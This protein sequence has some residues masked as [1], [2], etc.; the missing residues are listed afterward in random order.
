MSNQADAA[1]E[2]GLFDVLQDL[3][4]AG[5]LAG[6]DY[7]PTGPVAD[8]PAAQRR[9]RI[10]ATVRQ[11]RFDL[12]LALALSSQMHDVPE[13]LDLIAGRPLLY[14]EGDPWGRGKPIPDSMSAWLAVSDWVFSVGGEPQSSLLRRHGARVV[15]PTVHTY[16]HLLFAHEERAFDGERPPH[17]CVFI[18]SN[19]A[20]VPGL[21]GLPGSWDRRSLVMRLR[22]CLGPGFAVAG[23]GWPRRI[24]ASRVPF[25]QQGT[26]I[27]SGHILA[28][29][30]H[31]PR[32]SGYA[33]DRLAITMISG[34]AQVT[35]KHPDMSWAPPESSGVF[36][37]DT[38]RDV[39]Q[40]ILGLLEDPQGALDLGEAA[41]LW[42]QG[43][44]SLRHA[45][46]YMLSHALESLSPP[47][48]EP[49]SQ[50]TKTPW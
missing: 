35:T 39:E 9:A 23:A 29:W 11:A 49:W 33:S 12:V 32:T 13:V 44:L 27:R 21:T 28:N 46:T 40:T 10:I 26:F 34:R 15:L 22:R 25:A 45:L 19:L 16:D 30:D 14:W 24:G 8:E 18:G 42:A 17:P 7:V 48:I 3:V 1:R 43:R 47:D 6:Y 5:H 38:P 37:R 41:W 20:K 31:Y 4:A 36:L 2:P 50:L